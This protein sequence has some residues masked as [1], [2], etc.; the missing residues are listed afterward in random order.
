MATLG[1]I[2][3]FENLK[4][5]HELCRRDKQHKRGTIMFEMD[6]A[7]NLAE[8]VSRLCS[9]KY[10]PGKHK[11]FKLYDPKERIIDALPYKDRVVLM[12]FSKFVLEPMLDSRLVYD[13]AASRKNKGTS[14]AIG[15]LHE[16]MR[17]SFRQ[18]G[19][20]D[21]YFLKCDISKY[22]ASLDHDTLINKLG[23]IGFSDD[24]MWFIDVVVRSYGTC[25]VPLGNHTS[26]WFAVLYLDDLDRH[27]K[28]KL[29]VK[30]YSRYMDD[31][32][33]IHHDK[34]FLR[35]CKDEIDNM[36]QQLKL[37]LNKD[38]TQ[39][40]RL[41]DGL[42]YLGFNH[43]LTSTGKI[44]RR[45]RASAMVRQKRFLKTI[46]CLYQNGEVDKAWLETR[47][48]AFLNHLKGTDGV[49]VIKHHM[50]KIRK[51]KSR[52]LTKPPK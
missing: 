19:C 21:A 30:W 35:K 36:C 17:Q 13:N 34:E 16:F 7:R 42:D 11:Q 6:L 43:R 29:R 18:S 51:S 24:E 33:L 2:F 45:V 52:V 37:R 44:V 12:C 39:I 23:R 20:N 32:I 47:K 38:K 26:Q 15:R 40:G 46:G 48:R 14:F 22:F 49:N 50:R 5:S 27:I 25:G 31:F 9:R 8:L 41:G 4:K 28:E 1:E 3:T 10:K